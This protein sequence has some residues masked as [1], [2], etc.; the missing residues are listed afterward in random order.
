MSPPAS[1]TRWAE[2]SGRNPENQRAGL[3]RYVRDRPADP[4]GALFVGLDV[5]DWDKLGVNMRGPL[6]TG[7]YLIP[8][9]PT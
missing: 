9:R 2:P 7:Y 3:C 5:S 4:K 1:D 6:M 8:A